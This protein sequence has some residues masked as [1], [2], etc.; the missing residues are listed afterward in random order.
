[1]HGPHRASGTR[2]TL[3]RGRRDDETAVFSPL[4]S[5]F[6]STPSLDHVSG[7]PLRSVA[8]ALTQTFMK[9][10]F[11]SRVTKKLEWLTHIEA[12]LEILNE[13]I[14]ITNQDQR[15]LF[16]N[17]S[18]FVESD[19]RAW[20]KRS[21]CGGGTFSDATVNVELSV[22]AISR[23]L[24]RLKNISIYC[25]FIEASKGLHLLTPAGI[26]PIL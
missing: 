26:F 19:I 1:M 6:A 11:S 20:K 16:V 23:L 25:S 2:N 9:E 14:V 12:V 17:S 24:I 10:R 13:A 8:H 18:P 15:I 22:S 3:L 5:N 21:I 7:D 4:V